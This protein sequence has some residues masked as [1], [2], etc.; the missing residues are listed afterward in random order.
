MVG[1]GPDAQ[2]NGLVPG[3]R[4]PAGPQPKDAVMTTHL[5]RLEACHSSNVEAARI[6]VADPAKY[7]PDS[8]MAICARMVLAGDADIREELERR[9]K[10]AGLDSTGQSDCKETAT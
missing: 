8:L 9:K 10:R 6:I 7:P 3:R 2:G 4:T 1:P 5:E